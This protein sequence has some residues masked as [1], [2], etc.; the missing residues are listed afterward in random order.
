MEIR[1]LLAEDAE[2]YQTIR[3]ESLK[4]HPEAFGSSYEEEMGASVDKYRESLPIVYTFGAFENGSLI[5]V[6]TL[7]P[8]GKRKMKHRASIFAMYVAAQA[9]GKGVG[10]RLVEIAIEQA[11]ELGRIEQIHL[12]VVTSNESAKRL[13]SSLGFEVYG[14][15]KRALRIGDTYYDEELRVLFL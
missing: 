3:L 14:L 13:Y 7:F 9:R 10:K 1:R 6:V 12:Q 11:R 15:E 2:I 5:G 8:D 4:L